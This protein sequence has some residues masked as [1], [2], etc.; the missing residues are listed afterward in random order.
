MHTYIVLM[1]LMDQGIRAAKDAPDHI[2]AG[3][4]ALEKLGG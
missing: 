2:E 3:I 4:K 1:K